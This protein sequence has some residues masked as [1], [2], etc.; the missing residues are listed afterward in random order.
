MLGGESSIR[1]LDRPR[2]ARFRQCAIEWT[3]IDGWKNRTS[4][5]ASVASTKARDFISLRLL[6]EASVLEIV[7]PQGCRIRVD[8]QV[9]TTTLS[10]YWT[11][12]TGSST[13]RDL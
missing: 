7:D 1:D 3:E 11:C 13:V 6:E 8:G 4:E 12:W 5:N 2:F 10:Q 9:N